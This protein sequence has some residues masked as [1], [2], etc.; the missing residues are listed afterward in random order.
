MQPQ[1][2]IIGYLLANYNRF[3]ED[4][5][6]VAREYF[7]EL[8]KSM[9][10]SIKRG[11]GIIETDANAVATVMNKALEEV[12]ETKYAMKVKGNKI[13]SENTGF[14]PIEEG[15]RIM[16]GPW[17]IV[18]KNYSWQWFLGLAAG[19]NPNATMEVPES[20]IWGNNCCF[21]KIEVPK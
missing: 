7:Y 14:C 13:I 3:G 8:G 16:Q 5:L 17:E 10:Q 20:R 2:W 12:W 19:V 9:G 1:I 15:V 6:D 4:A 11:M 21:Y 18:C